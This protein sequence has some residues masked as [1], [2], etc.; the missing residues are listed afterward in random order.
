[1]SIERLKIKRQEIAARAEELIDR[2]GEDDYVFSSADKTEV[3]ELR[4]DAEELDS[5]IEG[6]TAMRSMIS[7]NPA[8]A[9]NDSPPAPTPNGK[10]IV[11]ERSSGNPA[12]ADI[13][14]RWRDGDDL[15]SG[16]AKRIGNDL[17]LAPSL[18]VSEEIKRAATGTAN[19][20]SPTDSSVYAFVRP[21][22]TLDFLGVLPQMIDPGEKE[23]AWITTSPDASNHAEDTD[24]TELTSQAAMMTMQRMTPTRTVARRGITEEGQWTYDDLASAIVDDG[25]DAVRDQLEAQVLNGNNTGSNFNGLFRSSPSGRAVPS[26]VDTFSTVISTFLAMVDGRYAEG[27]SDVRMVMNPDTYGW[28]GSVQNSVGTPVT[29]ALED[30][31]LRTRVSA[32]APAPA[33]VSGSTSNGRSHTVLVRR[34]NR[35]GSYAWPT[36]ATLRTG[37]REVVGVGT[38]FIMWAVSDFFGPNATQGRADFQTVGLLETAA[39]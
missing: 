24:L 7:K 8:L 36:W 1:M 9:F 23:F 4:L 20:V 31:G 33:V 21:N 15:E 35:A 32:H 30:R 17:A 13:L 29:L 25:R 2:M 27:L 19:I 34:G 16:V 18:F 39:V 11:G 10:L 26:T 12:L 5:Q 22:S 3:S 37:R 6:L 14:K 38:R 28:L